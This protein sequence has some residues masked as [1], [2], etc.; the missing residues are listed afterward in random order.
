VDLVL[1]TRGEDHAAAIVAALT[2][3]S[4]DVER[5]DGHGVTEPRA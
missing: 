5:F 1:E 2:E 4:Y 3:A